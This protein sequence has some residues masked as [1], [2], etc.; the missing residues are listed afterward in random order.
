[1]DDEDVEIVH[2]KNMLNPQ[3][4]SQVASWKGGDTINCKKDDQPR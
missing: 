2:E 3:P 1:M 4:H